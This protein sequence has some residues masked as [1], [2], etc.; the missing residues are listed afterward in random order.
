MIIFPFLRNSRKYKSLVI[1][2]DQWLP[3]GGDRARQEL[4]RAQE[5]FKSNRNVYIL[6]VLVVSYSYMTI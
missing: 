5:T 6:I 1:E 4:Q 2:R 3:Q